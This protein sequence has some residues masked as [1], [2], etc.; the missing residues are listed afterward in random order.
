M[1]LI[2]GKT[3]KGLKLLGREFLAIC[4]NKKLLVPIIAVLMVP[5]MYSGMFLGAFWDPYARLDKLPVAVV[6]MDEGAAFNDKALQIGDDLVEELKKESE[7][8]FQWDFVDL[9]TA[10]KGLEQEKYYLMIKV[11]KDFS[12]NATT[13]TDST[14]QHLQ[15]EYIPNESYNFLSSQIGGTAMLKIKEKLEGEVTKQYAETIFDGIAKAGEDIQKAADGSKTLDEGVTKLQDGSGKVTDGLNKLGDGLITFQDKSGQLAAGAKQ[16]SDGLAQIYPKTIEI[17]DGIKQLDNGLAELLQKVEK[18]NQELEQKVK[19]KASEI[20]QLPKEV[21]KFND[22]VKELQSVSASLETQISQVIASQSNLSEQDK[23]NLI[24]DIKKLSGISKG[25]G[26]GA[27]GLSAKVSNTLPSLNNTLKGMEKSQVD[28]VLGINQLKEG[29]S[30]LSG[31]TPQLV[32]A[33]NQL[34]DGSSQVTAGNTQLNS[35]VGDMKP[36][37]GKLTDGSTQVTD[38]LNKVKDGSSELSTGLVEGAEKSGEIQGDQKKYD[39]LASPVEV[40]EEKYT[41]VPNYGTGFAPYFLSLGLFVGALLI[42]IVFPLRDSAGTP[43]S[44]FDWFI[45]KFGVLLF[46][47]IAQALISDVVL[48]FGLGVEVQSVPMFILF[49]IITSLAFLTLVQFLVTTFGDAGRF[50]AIVALI[51]Q[52]TTSAGTFPLELIPE[53]LQAFN[54]WLPMTYSVAGLKA[55]ISSGDF[56]FMWQNAQFLFGFIALAVVGTIAILTVF[57]KRQYSAVTTKEA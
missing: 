21:K 53:W 18:G 10:E 11:P 42:S 31:G 30:K 15:L 46:V 36:N 25:L 57:F 6:N 51:L 41:P 43:T 44:G 3:M 48:L 4:R 45:S 5:V 28:L 38:G 22:G 20:G 16:V 23:L 7:E 27:G 26:E 47:G 40:K 37:V 49:S 56:A 9:E 34:S 1:F 2:G 8:S 32:S 52:L 13:L 39:M 29:S 12:K 50:I 17:N 19:G 54:T 33:I 35:A 55:V 24:T 14:P